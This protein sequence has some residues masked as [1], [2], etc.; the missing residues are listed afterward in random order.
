MSRADFPNASA[1]PRLPDME[2]LL[3]QIA[4]ALLAR[5]QTLATAESCTGGLASALLTSLPGSSNWFQG[6]IIA[7]SNDI[8]RKLLAVRPATL[9][10]YGAVSEETAKEMAQGACACLCVP[11]SVAIT[12]LAGPDGGTAQ[13]KVGLVCFAWAV[14]GKLSSATR[15]FKGNRDEV[16]LAAA[17]QALEGLLSRLQSAQGG[18]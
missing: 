17:L 4:A 15:H 8:K 11:C 3:S 18:E 7:Y 5:Q 10:A 6:G 14:N 1:W 16:R 9:A 2:T 12:G 13:K